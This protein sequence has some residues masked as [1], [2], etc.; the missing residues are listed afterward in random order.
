MIQAVSKE[1]EATWRRPDEGSWRSS[2]LGLDLQRWSG[3][4]NVKGHMYSDPGRKMSSK[5]TDVAEQKSLSGSKH[6]YWSLQVEEWGKKENEDIHPQTVQ[7][8]PL[9]SSFRRKHSLHCKASR[10][11][12]DQQSQMTSGNQHKYRDDMTVISSEY[13]SS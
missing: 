7:S 6:I 13:Y 1:R 5:G 9:K 2:D 3:F 12:V 10:S 11:M 8:L 4:R